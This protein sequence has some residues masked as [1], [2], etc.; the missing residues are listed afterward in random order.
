[1]RL[2]L[3]H[4]VAAIL[5]SLFGGSWLCRI[6]AST[7]KAVKKFLSIIELELSPLEHG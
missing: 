3:N 6:T 5:E 4:Y 2:E 1:M 7:S